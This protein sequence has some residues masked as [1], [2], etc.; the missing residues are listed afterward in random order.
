LKFEALGRRDP[1]LRQART[2]FVRAG[3]VTGAP[4]F[5]AA[6]AVLF[7]KCGSFDWCSLDLHVIQSK[8]FYTETKTRK[9]TQLAVMYRTK[10]LTLLSKTEHT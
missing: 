4:V 5:F 10:Q 2:T 3:R 9:E 6:P 7:G 8:K 1:S